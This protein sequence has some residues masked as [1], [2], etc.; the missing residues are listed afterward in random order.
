MRSARAAE[1]LLLSTNVLAAAAIA[2]TALSGSK[3]V[4]GL[5]QLL[6]RSFPAARGLGVGIGGALVLAAA[7]VAEATATREVV[8]AH[9]IDGLIGCGA[10]AAAARLSL[11]KP[12][13]GFHVLAAAFVAEFAAAALEV[14]ADLLGDVARESVV[15]WTVSEAATIAVVAGTVVAKVEALAALA[16]N[17]RGLDGLALSVKELAVLTKAALAVVAEGPAHLLFFF[18]HVELI[19]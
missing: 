4:A 18:G 13:L 2:E 19:Y 9:F 7:F 5:I 16:G 10:A 12:T 1:R 11:R 6:D 15:I 8:A 3:V 14:A 17:G